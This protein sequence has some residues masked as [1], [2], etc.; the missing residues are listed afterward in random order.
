M[1][2]GDGTSTPATVAP[3]GN[4]AFQITAKPDYASSGDFTFQVNVT[5]QTG[6]QSSVMGTAFV[7]PALDQHFISQLYKD[8]LERSVDPAGLSFWSAQLENGVTRSAVVSTILQSSE[9]LRAQVDQLYSTLLHRGADPAG[10]QAGVNYLALGG[11]WEGLRSIF[12]SSPEYQKLSDGA[13]GSY[14]GDLY[15]VLLGRAVDPLGFAYW[16][17]VVQNGSAA[18]VVDSIAQSAEAK[19]SEARS[20]LTQ[21][22]H[23]AADDGGTA[24]FAQELTNGTR[25]QDVLAAIFSSY[26]YYIKADSSALGGN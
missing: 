26:E 10:E 21:T 18:Q 15:Q 9:A 2:W 1:S 4:G 19:Q 25:Y 12:L 11:S 22:L 23:R 16:Q 7:A 6:Q 13:G 17:S 8:L 24:F 5:D 14:I 3:D 20:L